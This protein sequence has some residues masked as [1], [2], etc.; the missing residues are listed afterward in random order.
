MVVAVLATSLSVATTPVD[1]VVATADAVVVV[2]LLHFAAAA[3]AAAC[4]RCY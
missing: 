4:R 1:K 3:A 2:E